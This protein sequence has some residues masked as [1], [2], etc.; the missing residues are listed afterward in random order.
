[1]L[2][3]PLSVFY[4]NAMI[5][6]PRLSSG[7]N[8]ASYANADGSLRVDLSHSYGKRTRRL[9]RVVHKKLAA[10]TLQPATNSFASMSTSIVVDTPLYGYTLAEQQ[11]VA[12]AIISVLSATYIPRFLGGE[13]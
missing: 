6:I 2:P 11:D 3:D 4:P 13:V 10:D 9:A 12:E 8:N 7:P 5:T 1:M